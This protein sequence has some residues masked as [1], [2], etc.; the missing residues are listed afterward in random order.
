VRAH[1]QCLG[2][3]L[4]LAEKFY[5]IL[6][7]FFLD[8]VTSTQVVDIWDAVALDRSL[9]AGE[10]VGSRDDVVDLHYTVLRELPD[11]DH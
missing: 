7:L 2:D 11:A 3:F 9:K 8:G 6:T 10:P 1:L 4:I 5:V